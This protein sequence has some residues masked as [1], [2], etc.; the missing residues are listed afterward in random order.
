MEVE[1]ELNIVTIMQGTI[2]NR[3]NLNDSS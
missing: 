2:A 3:P 1:Y